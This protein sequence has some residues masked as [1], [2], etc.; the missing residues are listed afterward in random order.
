MVH[1]FG[2]ASFGHLCWPIWSITES[3]IQNFRTS[4]TYMLEYINEHR[5]IW[6]NN[7]K[8]IIQKKHFFFL[9]TTHT[10]IHPHEQH[11]Q[12]PSSLPRPLSLFPSS[13]HKRDRPF[14]VHADKLDKSCA[15]PINV[16]KKFIAIYKL[17]LSVQTKFEN[18]LVLPMKV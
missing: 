10:Y 9:S 14:S 12:P 5:E 3:P 8:N 1:L 16:Q 11:S 4:I 6:V 13:F 18:C 7:G 17:S 15:H 2:P